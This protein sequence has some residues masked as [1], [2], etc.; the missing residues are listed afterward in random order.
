MSSGSLLKSKKMYYILFYKTV[1][2]YEEKRTPY[3]AE[4]L[5]YA[6]DAFKRGELIM[7]GAYAEPGDGAVLVFKGESPVVAE[8]FAQGDIYVRSGIVSQ[9]NVRKWNVVIG[10]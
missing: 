8:Q 1:E 5:K 7:A 4:H 9:W 2:N 10:G 6:Q 3:R